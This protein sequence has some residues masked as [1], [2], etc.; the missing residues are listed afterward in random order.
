[1]PNCKDRQFYNKYPRWAR[2]D[3]ENK[4]K[5]NIILHVSD[6]LGLRQREYKNYELEIIYFLY[7]KILPQFI[8]LLARFNLR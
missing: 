8:L 5:V 1:M 7:L 4:H 6:G 2:Y 3:M